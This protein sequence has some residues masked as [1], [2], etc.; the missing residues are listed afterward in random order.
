[1]QFTNNQSYAFDWVMI[2]KEV[3]KNVYTILIDKF[4]GKSHA[5]D[6]ESAGS[7]TLM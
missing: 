4:L 5:E 1:M 6:Q 3:Y 7:I 2:R